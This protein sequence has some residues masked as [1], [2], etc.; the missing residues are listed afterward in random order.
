MLFRSFQG[1]SFYNL[2][3]T[4]SSGSVLFSARKL[5]LDAELLP[6]FREKKIVISRAYLEGPVFSTVLTP[7]RP[8]TAPK[9]VM[10]K[11][12]GQIPVPVM[13]ER[14]A[15]RKSTRLN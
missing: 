11:L 12:S 2:K 15:D 4:D 13:P 9:P 14:N 1:L 5:R 8:K 6:F 10:T 7:V 3:V